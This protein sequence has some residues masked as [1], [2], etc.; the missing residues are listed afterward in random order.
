[1]VDPAEFR[2]LFGDDLADEFQARHEGERFAT[3]YRDRP[4]VDEPVVIPISP[5]RVVEVVLGLLFVASV[6][7]LSVYGIAVAL[8]KAG[9]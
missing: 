4:P 9:S 7:A 2:R 3:D 8:G 5:R 1:M 6:F